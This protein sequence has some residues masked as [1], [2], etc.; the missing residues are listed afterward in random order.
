MSFSHMYTLGDPL[1]GC[2]ARPGVWDGGLGGVR[3]VQLHQRGGV[4]KIRLE[5]GERGHVVGCVFFCVSGIVMGF[6][7]ALKLTKHAVP[8]IPNT[9]E[10]I[11]FLRIENHN[12]RVKLWS[13]YEF[14]IG[15]DSCRLC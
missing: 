12:N 5:S 15:N 10:L 14:S 9:R 1:Q 11:L 6:V 4:D 3:C 13:T 2:L 7:S 8:V